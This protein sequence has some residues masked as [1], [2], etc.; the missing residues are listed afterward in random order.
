MNYN[1]A[2]ALLIISKNTKN[3][4]YNMNPRQQEQPPEPLSTAAFL[5]KYSI[6]K[7]IIFTIFAFAAPRLNR[8]LHANSSKNPKISPAMLFNF[9]IYALGRLTELSREFPTAFGWPEAAILINPIIDPRAYNNRHIF[10]LVS[11]GS[12]FV[13]ELKDDYLLDDER[14]YLRKYE[15]IV[16]DAFRQQDT[17]IYENL[18]KTLDFGPLPTKFREHYFSLFA[19]TVNTAQQQLLRLAATNRTQ[20]ITALKPTKLQPWRNWKTE[21]RTVRNGDGFT[22]LHIAAASG[23]EATAQL[24]MDEGAPLDSLC[25]AGLPPLYYAIKFGHETLTQRLIQAMLTNGIDLNINSHQF[26]VTSYFIAR[27]LG[28]ESY[29]IV[30]GVD[31]T[32]LC[33]TF[34][35]AGYVEAERVIREKESQQDLLYDESTEENDALIAATVMGAMNTFKALYHAKKERDVHYSCA[36]RYILSCN[37]LALAAGFNQ[38]EVA[39]HILNNHAE[40]LTAYFSWKKRRYTLLG[41]DDDFTFDPRLLTCS[42]RID[43][44]IRYTEALYGG[45]NIL[46]VAADIQKDSAAGRNIEAVE[47]L[48]QD[49]REGNFVPFQHIIDPK[50][51]E[52]MIENAEIFLDAL[53]SLQRPKS[54]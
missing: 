26:A 30:E 28:R 42:P 23:N 20:E 25:K 18:F 13:A 1:L 49:I 40:Q 31:Q 19:T 47:A 32:K 45:C 51:K 27:E 14:S 53:Q 37:L 24:L 33:R 54:P 2:I 8:R 15:C 36:Q 39:R 41:L 50:L 52:K 9:Y 34:R 12:E 7:D 21:L 46:D 43:F 16:R 22:L 5:E 17:V 11:R 10:R 29:F 44:Y 3:C 35:T 6:R 38:F 4:R 48:L